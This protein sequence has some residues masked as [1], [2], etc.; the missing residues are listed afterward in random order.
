[1]STVIALQGS[2]NLRNIFKD[3][4]EKAYRRPVIKAF[5]KAAE[6]VKKAMSNSLPSNLKN[7]NK[8]IKI[9][10]GKGKS[11][12]LAVG[13]FANEGIYRNSKGQK[14]DPYQ[15]ALWHNYGTLDWRANR[16]YSFKTPVRRKIKSG[17]M[18]GIRPL[19]FVE[20]GWQKSKGEAQRIFEDTAD[21]EIVSF[22]E[23]EAAK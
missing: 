7:L 16:F 4:P 23:K 14:W 2:E 20:R 15:L 12:T 3:F 19:L 8:V 17:S 9:K 18:A 10:P 5:R 6:P 1:M 11:M 22:F 21:K 13:F